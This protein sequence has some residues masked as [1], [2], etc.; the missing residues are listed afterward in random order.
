VNTDLELARVHKDLAFKS[1][2]ARELWI[3]RYRSQTS[4][5]ERRAELKKQL[6]AAEGEISMLETEKA[7]LERIA[8]YQARVPAEPEYHATPDVPFTVTNEEDVQAD[9]PGT[10]KG[11]PRRGRPKIAKPE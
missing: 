11:T 10:P 2:E 5:M 7:M 6:D 1:R 3:A 4:S 8:K 9:P